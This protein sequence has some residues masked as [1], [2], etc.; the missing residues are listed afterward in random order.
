MGRSGLE[1]EKIRKLRVVKRRCG[2]AFSE[3]HLKTKSGY[4][5][6]PRALHC[7]NMY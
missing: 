3:C 5:K 7:C 4:C 1:L 2:A 6:A